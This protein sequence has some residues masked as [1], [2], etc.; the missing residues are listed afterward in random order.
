MH[1]VIDLLLSTL[2]EAQSNDINALM[3]RDFVSLYS[4]IE[5]LKKGSKYSDCRCQQL[6]EK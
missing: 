4:R 3:S 6:L 5:I 1:T 2:K